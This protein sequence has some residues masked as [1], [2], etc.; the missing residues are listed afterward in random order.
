VR[1]DITAR[2]QHQTFFERSFEGEPAAN[3]FEGYTIADAVLSWRTEPATFTLGVQN[4]FDEDYVTYFSDTQSPTD[5][6]SYYFGRGRTL[7]L[8][9]SKSF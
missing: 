3:S 6:L 1:G 4:L 2:L 9:V 5:N 8:G 7:T